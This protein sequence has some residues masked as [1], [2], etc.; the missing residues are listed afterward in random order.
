MTTSRRRSK[1]DSCD[2]RQR[3]LRRGPRRRRCWRSGSHAGRSSRI[4]SIR[5]T[6]AR[7]E[8]KYVRSW[9][10]PPM[11]RS[12]RRADRRA[13]GPLQ[14]AVQRRS[15]TD[16][17]GR[18][19][20]A[21]VRGISRPRRRRGPSTGL[22]PLGR[23]AEAPGRR[24]SGAAEAGLADPRRHRREQTAVLR[25]RDRAMSRTAV[26]LRDGLRA[27]PSA[28]PTAAHAATLRPRYRRSGG[29]ARDL[30]R[31]EAV[32]GHGRHR[33][34]ASSAGVMTGAPSLDQLPARLS[35]GV[36]VAHFTAPAVMPRIR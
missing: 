12:G 27:A 9:W 32:D 23:S 8:V 31:G 33:K 24:R 15:R 17:Q 35:Q 20:R 29:G 13:E 5:E 19:R 22:P 2:R 21:R 30:E 7:A 18:R 36:E 16:R 11:Q 26:R 10:R 14:A 34:A 3:R 1:I 6:A 4:G 28:A 25:S